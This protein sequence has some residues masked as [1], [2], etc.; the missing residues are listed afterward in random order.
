MEFLGL[1][2][3]EVYQWCYFHARCRWFTGHASRPTL[4]AVSRRRKSCARAVLTTYSLPILFWSQA[5]CLTSVI[6]AS[7]SKD[8]ASFTACR[9]LQGLVGTIPQVIGLCIINDVFFF[10]E[11]ARKINLWS[12]STLIGPHAGPFIAAF[13]IQKIDWHQDFGVLAGFYGV[14]TLL[15]IIFGDETLFDRDQPPEFVDT[16]S[17]FRRRVGLLIG[18]TGFRD[19]R[20]PTIWM[21]VK[22]MFSIS[23]LPYLLAPCKSSY[24]IDG[25][26]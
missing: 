3:S 6:G 21:A 4:R 22:T 20:R 25:I 24:S 1:T 11:R 12:F 9:T 8:Y 15:V 13:L 17:W 23:Y 14:S 16:R 18:I 19:F 10:H 2:G 5:L 26:V 7:Q